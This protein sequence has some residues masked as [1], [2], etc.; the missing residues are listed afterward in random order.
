VAGDRRPGDVPR[1]SVVDGEQP[2][3]R[4]DEPPGCS[5]PLKVIAELLGGTVRIA[6]RKLLGYVEY[7]MSAQV[8]KKLGMV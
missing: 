6:W 1:S 2:G 7:N 5:V 3:V 8:R 4:E